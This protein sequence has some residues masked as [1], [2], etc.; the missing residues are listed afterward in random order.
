MSLY[1]F[2][3][4]YKFTPTLGNKRIFGKI[5]EWVQSYSTKEI[6][7]YREAYW[8]IEYVNLPDESVIAKEVDDIVE[9]MELSEP[10]E[11]D[12][13]RKK[14]ESK[15]AVDTSA[16]KATISRL[17]EDSHFVKAVDAINR[18]LLLSAEVDKI[19]IESMKKNL[20]TKDY[21]H[22]LLKIDYPK[23]NVL[24]LYDFI[25]YLCLQYSKV[26]NRYLDQKY[27]ALAVQ[28]GVEKEFLQIKHSWVGDSIAE[29]K[30]D[31]KLSSK[32]IKD[33][34][35]G[36]PFGKQYM[37]DCRKND[38]RYA[39]NGLIDKIKKMMVN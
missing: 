28:E 20:S 32:E 39:C 11:I 4:N 13:V 15:Y 9:R 21:L 12:W 26:M 10:S 29:V 2:C 5:P 31:N 23:V 14:V 16:Y 22:Q 19:A 35:N 38:V 36:L 1:E 37:K 7:E 25:G 17:K 33:I 18:L 6:S 27:M 34:M 30:F 8:N 3:N 24:L